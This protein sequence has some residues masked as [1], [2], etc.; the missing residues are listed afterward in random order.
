MSVKRT[1]SLVCGLLIPMFSSSASKVT[2]STSKK[3]SDGSQLTEVDAS[4]L[5][6]SQNRI[7]MLEY[8]YGIL[9]NKRLNDVS[10]IDQQTNQCNQLRIL[11]NFSLTV[12]NTSVRTRTG[13]GPMSGNHT[14]PSTAFG[15]TRR[16]FCDAEE[17]QSSH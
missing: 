11:S 1:C 9:H 12:E 10:V 8:D 7:K 5:K 15:R 16:S 6:D 13:A 2:A 14:S 4:T 17:T 3:S